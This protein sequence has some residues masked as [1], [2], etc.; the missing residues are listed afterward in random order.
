MVYTQRNARVFTCQCGCG[1]S[2]L[3]SPSAKYFEDY[4]R[5]RA[6]KARSGKAIQNPRRDMSWW[7]STTGLISLARMES[8][9]FCVSIVNAW[10][11]FAKTSLRQLL[12]Y[13][14]L[15]SSVKPHPKFRKY[16]PHTL[17]QR[18]KSGYN[19]VAWDAV[20][21]HWFVK[22]PPLIRRHFH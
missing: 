8:F 13:S 1:R 6:W 9:R 3:G 11:E 21:V 12:E 14:S 16:S 22:M 2:R 5:V 15:G 19:L 18:R 20:C 17:G 10:I 4:C 7:L